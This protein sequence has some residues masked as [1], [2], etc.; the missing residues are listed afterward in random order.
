MIRNHYISVFA[1]PGRGRLLLRLTMTFWISLALE[2]GW[3]GPVAAAAGAAQAARPSRG[4][5]PESI[6]A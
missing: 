2:S 6:S 3:P 4:S 5:G 1:G